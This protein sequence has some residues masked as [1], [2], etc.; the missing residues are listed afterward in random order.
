MKV[1]NFPFVSELFTRRFLTVFH[2][3]VMACIAF[4]LAFVLRYGTGN[5]GHEQMEIIQSGAPLFGLTIAILSISFGLH[6][7]LWS[8]TTTDDLTRVIAV[9]AGA[10][11]LVF[12]ALFLTS[13]LDGV[14]RSVPLILAA[15]TLIFLGGSRFFV[16]LA[17]RPSFFEGISRSDNGLKLPVMLVG[18]NHK[19][20]LFLRWIQRTRFVPYQAVAILDLDGVNAGQKL[21]GVPIFGPGKDFEAIMNWLERNGQKPAWMILCDTFDADVMASLTRTAR[22]NDTKVAKMPSL[23][24][25]SDNTIDQPFRLKPIA[26]EDLLGR[27]QVKLDL[28]PLGELIH[29]RRVMVTGGGGTIGSELCRQ[30]A[31]YGPREL[32]IVDSCE[33]NLYAIERDLLAE[34]TGS[35]IN[36]V[37]L[38]TDVRD[39]DTLFRHF[40]SYRP[41]LVFH[42]AALKHVPMI[43]ANPIEAIRT[44]VFGTRN[45]ADAAKRYDALGMV[46]ISTDKAVNPTSVMGATKWLAEQYCL[47]QDRQAEGQRS[48]RF[49][50]VRFGN[51]LGSSG[52]VVPLFKKQLAAGGP[53][54]VTHPEIT[55]YFMT[56][57]EATQLVLHAAAHSLENDKNRGNVLVLDMGKPIKVYELACHMARLAGLEPNKDIE[58]KSIGLRPGEKLYEEL[59]ATNETQLSSQIIGVNAASSKPPETRELRKTFELLEQLVSTHQSKSVIDALADIVIGFRGDKD[60]KKQ[61]KVAA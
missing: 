12:L 37:P 35:D 44:N 60:R 19:T 38:L 14:P 18:I 23:M 30:I 61:K 56:V 32:F 24:T 22:Q 10:T 50:V 4:G 53:L 15:I 2:D 27:G 17:S 29:A 31:S 6:K 3:F 59:F 21:Y 8:Y 34:E 45:V 16:R 11:G 58:I 43:E 36:I 40:K 13:R 7:H 1:F 33:Y 20:E 5:L 54:T 42:A 47:L 51:V 49:I 55:R 41:E 28:E 57:Y 52:S 9:V 46:S 26:I 39:R 25:L 48:T